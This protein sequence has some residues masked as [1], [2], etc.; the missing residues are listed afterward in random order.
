MSDIEPKHLAIAAIG[1]A[2]VGGALY[3]SRKGASSASPAGELPVRSAALDYLD[4]PLH[5]RAGSRYRAKLETAGGAAPFAEA[6]SA[7]D[8]KDALEKLGF[9][10][11]NVY[12]SAS[13]LPADWPP[14]EAQGATASTRFFS[15]TWSP[16]TLDVP[17]P[18][19][20]V[21]AWTASAAAA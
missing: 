20:L 12:A 21:S 3:V 2:L 5:F 10:N 15:G 18:A 8:V 14:T 4:S 6:S 11:V 7:G 13:D 19:A 16:S 17:R 9:S 1:I